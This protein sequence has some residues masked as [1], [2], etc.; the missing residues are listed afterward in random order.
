VTAKDNRLDRLSETLSAKERAVLVLRSWKDGKDEDP[1]WRRTMPSGQGSEF[2]HYIGLMNGVNTRIGVYLLVV[3]REV[4]K[5]SLRF[6]W[7]C[8]FLLWQWQAVEFWEHIIIAAKEPVTESEYKELERKAREEYEPVGLLAYVLTE[9]HDGF[10]EAD[11]MPDENGHHEHMVTP[12]AWERVQN[13]KAK[14]LAALVKAG[15][16]P[17]Q[18]RG[19]GLTV[20]AG[21]FY[22]R[23][24][25]PAPVYPEWARWYE[26]V[27]DEQAQDAA[28]RRGFLERAVAAYKRGPRV[29]IPHL[30]G[31][32]GSNEV[33]V[34]DP[35][36]ID[37]IVMALKD[38][39]RDGVQAR[40]R[41]LRATEVV[42]EEVAQEFDEDPC[43][44]VLR[45]EIDHCRSN[46]EELHRD[47]QSYLPPFEL[48]EP[49][50]EALALVRELVEREVRHASGDTSVYA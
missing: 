41:E 28:T 4:E 44:P 34:D 30:V 49:G 39:L 15:T 14:E 38:T 35:S 17:G 24:G 37:E 3:R 27:P 43:V 1:A 26:V 47:L 13:E 23:L 7:L 21:P 5:L 32:S 40:W 45:H 36:Q 19:K 9:H 6:G 16:L 31:L 29:L 8:T 12:E 48:E 46:L 25:E 2:N 18:G 33:H 20:K 10:A 42:V 11:L 22:D 50:E